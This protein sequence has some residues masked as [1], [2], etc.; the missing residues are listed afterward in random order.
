M[1]RNKVHGA[2]RF[3]WSTSTATTN[4]VLARLRCG[5]KEAGAGPAVQR[6]PVRPGIDGL[7]A[8]AAR[9]A[10]VTMTRI[11][12]VDVDG[13]ENGSADVPS[14]PANRP[15]P[16][17]GEGRSSPR[18]APTCP[19]RSSPR[20]KQGRRTGVPSPRQ[21][22]P[23]PRPPWASSWNDGFALT[24]QDFSP[25]TGVGEERHARPGTSRS[26]VM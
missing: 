25:K 19:R 3:P 8:P 15:S 2:Q 14:L 7:E 22:S 12:Q 6:C 21:A 26:W 1:R 20:N 5:R 4:G 9:V 17:R 11:T 24:Q 18:P 16:D 23:T 13:V 10:D